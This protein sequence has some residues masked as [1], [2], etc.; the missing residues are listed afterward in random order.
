MLWPGAPACPNALTNT[1]ATGR[2]MVW[3]WHALRLAPRLGRAGPGG[4][5]EQ[6]RA[7]L[8]VVSRPGT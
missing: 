8:G 4:W 6:N 5:V 3:A 1:R 2:G 7:K